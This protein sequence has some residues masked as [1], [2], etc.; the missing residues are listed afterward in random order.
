MTAL[1]DFDKVRKACFGPTLDPQFDMH[2][3]HFKTS[4]KALDIPET[5]KLHILFTHVV[6]FCKNHGPLGRHSEQASESVHH[7]FEKMWTKYKVNM[8]NTQYKDRLLTAVLNYN[9]YHM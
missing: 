3:A 2:I 6:K 9:A 7:D 5:P 4:F 8:S 1:R